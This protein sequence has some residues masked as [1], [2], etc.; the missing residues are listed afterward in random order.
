MGGLRRH[1]CLCLR[2]F[3][4]SSAPGRLPIPAGNGGEDDA[5]GTPLHPG[6][7][8]QLGLLLQGLRH[9]LEERDTDLWV[10]DASSPEHHG[11]LDLGSQG[12]QLLS[13][14]KLGVKVVLAYSGAEPHL[15]QGGGLLRLSGLPVLLGLDVLELAVVQQP[16]NRG[17]GRWGYLNQVQ[18]LLLRESQGLLQ[19]QNAQLGIILCND[20]DVGRPN[21]LVYSIVLSYT[22]LPL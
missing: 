6:R 13:G 4:L 1:R 20:S 14:A 21:T 12:Q 15:P 7:S 17:I 9:F 22:C 10:S 5:E 11:E 2:L 3:F 18:V 19:G 16:A 8:V